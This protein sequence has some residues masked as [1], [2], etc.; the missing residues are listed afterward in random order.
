[1]QSLLQWKSHKYYTTCVCVCVFV[2][3]GSPHALRM[4]M[5]SSVASAA[6]QH[7]STLSHK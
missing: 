4:H 1:M 6:L 2:A 3:L 5:L 7:F